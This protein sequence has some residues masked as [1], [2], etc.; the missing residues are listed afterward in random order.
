MAARHFFMSSDV[1][2]EGESIFLKQL[3]ASDFLI[4]TPKWI[5]WQLIGGCVIL[6]IVPEVIVIVPPVLYQDSGWYDMRD[7]GRLDNK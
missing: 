4:S 5:I 6:H 7:F 2:F 3:Q 1:Q